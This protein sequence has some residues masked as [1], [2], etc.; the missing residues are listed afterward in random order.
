M[1]RMGSRTGEQFGLRMGTVITLAFLFVVASASA[2]LAHYVYE[3]AEVWGNSEGKCLLVRSEISHGNGGGY[4]KGSDF[5]YRR[6]FS[7]DCFYE[8]DR[9]PGYLRVRYDLLK[10]TGSQWAY[11]RGIGN[12]YNPTTRNIFDVPHYWGSSPPCGSAYYGT[13]TYGQVLYNGA[14]RGPTAMWSG[15]HYLPP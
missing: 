3:K 5:T 15:S 4:S 12:V 9:G 1:K 6:A 8:W 2:A 10:W 7:Q 14:W 13:Q 11:C